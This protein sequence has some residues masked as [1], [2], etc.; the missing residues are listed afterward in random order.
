MAR[1]LILHHVE[2]C[3]ETALKSYGLT[4]DRLASKIVDHL[5]IAGYDRVILT[6]F[7]DIKPT[8]EHFYTGLTGWVDDWYEYGYGWEAPK[9]DYEAVECLGNNKYRIWDQLWTDNTR[10]HSDIVLIPD[11]V[12]ELKNDKVFLAGAFDG[13][14]IADMQ[15]ALDAAGVR[16]TRVEELI[17]G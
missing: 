13:E 2:P 11:W 17:V 5:R 10:G 9:D 15:D 4:F 6:Q 16:Y 3:W 14:C 7:E 12:Q 1:V 8:E